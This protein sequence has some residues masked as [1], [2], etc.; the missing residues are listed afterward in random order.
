MYKYEE[1]EEYQEK[2]EQEL[3][4][5]YINEVLRGT[6]HQLPTAIGNLPGYFKLIG[7]AEFKVF[8]CL[9]NTVVRAKKKYD[10]VHV[11]EN[12]Y[13]KGK[14]ACSWTDKELSSRIDMDRKSIYRCV[15]SLESKG[16]IKREQALNTRTNIN[17]TVYIVGDIVI[18]G[19]G[20]IET[21]YCY[22]IL[23]DTEAKSM[24]EEA[25]K[26]EENLS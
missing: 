17:Q 20:N 15:K 11:Y 8:E 3:S 10:P 12:Y 25:V 24:F 9:K 5:I 16:Y 13:L 14:L 22:K 7:S 21:I 4:A 18:T 26:N 1:E 6:F 19:I 23:W 2:S